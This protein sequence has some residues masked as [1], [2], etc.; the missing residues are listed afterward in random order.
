GRLAPSLR[1]R[2]EWFS[3][4]RGEDLG[5]AEGRRMRLWHDVAAAFDDHDVLVWPDDTHDPYRHDDEEAAQAKD[6]RLHYIAPMLNLPAVTVPCGFSS[7]G[8]PLG[9]QVT[10]RPGADLLILQVAH[11]YEQATGYGAR[12]PLLD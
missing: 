3:S 7:N 11:A 12:R 8:I 10:G 9:L 5:R 4:L 6:W 1:D 2:Y